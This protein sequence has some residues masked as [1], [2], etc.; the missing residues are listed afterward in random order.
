MP[1]THLQLIKNYAPISA[2]CDAYDLPVIEGTIPA[3]LNGVLYRNGTNPIFPP[4]G[5]HHWF[6][7]EGMVHAIRL[8]NGRASYRNRWVRTEMYEAQRRAGER[9]VSTSVSEP[10]PEDGAHL[11]RHMAA[12]HALA[13]AGQL[14]ALDEW[15]LPMV[16]D[17]DTLE[18]L[19]TTDF[20]GRHKGP[21]TA[22]PKLDPETG[23]LIAFGYQA[24]GIGSRLMSLTVLSADGQVSRHE[25]F[26]APFC[27]VVH[28][29]A[30][31]SEHIVI[32]LFS[33]T[34]S[35]ER[36]MSGG[37]LV[38]YDPSLPTYFG[39]M[40]RHGAAKEIQWIEADPCY[41]FHTM[42]SFTVHRNGQ[43]EVVLDMMKY[44]NL[45]L[46]PSTNGEPA[47]EWIRDGNGTLV[48]WTIELDTKR[49]SEKVLSDLPGEF[50]IVDPRFVGRSYSH[51]FYAAS[52]GDWEDGAFFD[53][54][55]HINLE[56]GERRDY[57][58]ENGEYF[59]E[60]IFVPRTE[61]SR[62]GDGWILTVAY[63]AKKNLSD[64]LILDTADIRTGPVARVELPTRVP[65]GFHGSWNAG[66]V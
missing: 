31:T 6:L 60:P 33:A 65:Y 55:S 16:L 13:F 10:S 35:L 58:P 9:L 4:L 21:F 48:R 64:L 1:T 27:G 2:E 51:G 39:V 14:L 62:E 53:T 40:P 45:P 47:P 54:I 5:D 43:V 20:E 46:F 7:S 11:P 12:T 30:I 8:R 26:D 57:F 44:P 49:V 59:L 52:R 32:P 24:D 34:I 17:Q 18:T 23:E 37:P 56:S 3:D 28:D 42:N 25:V 19:G 29:F 38:A 66:V 63:N 50:P 15:N 36:A 61:E 22:H 41:A